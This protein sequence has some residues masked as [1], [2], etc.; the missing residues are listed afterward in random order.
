MDEMVKNSSQN[1][2][3]LSI[4]DLCEM[5]ISKWYWFLV[6][7][8]A[9]MAVT[10][11]YLM[12]QP[13]VYTRTATV[14]I[15]DDK[16]G[17]S[18]KG[19][20]S[21]TFADL[22]FLRFQTN[23]YNE[24]FTI[25]SPTLMAE[26]V[27][28]LGLNEAYSTREGLKPYSY[29]NNSPVSVRLVDRQNIGLRFDIRIGENGEYTVEKFAMGQ[30]K[31]KEPVNG[32]LGDTLSTPV[33]RIEILPT[34]YMTDDCV[35]KVVSYS[36]G[37]VDAVAANYVKILDA[38]LGDKDATILNLSIENTSVKRAEDILNTLIDVYNEKWILDKNQISESTSNFINDRLQMIER[39]LGEV[40]EVIAEYKS[41]HL[42][43]DVEEASRLYMNQ[44]ASYKKE[45]ATLNT[46]LEMAKFIRE[47]LSRK[48]AF[49]LLPVNSGIESSQVESQI[50]EYNAMVL[51]HNRLLSHSSDS[52][53][54]VK[55]MA[56]SL[57]FMRSA[58]EQ[59]VDNLI[60]SLNNQ[61]RTVTTEDDA[62]SGR[63][64]SGP[65]Q[66]KY[67]LSVERQQKVKA[68]LYLYLLQKREENELSRAFTAY[69][70]RVIT[71]PCGSPKPTSPNKARVL[72]VALFF[73]MALPAGVIFLVE[74]MNTRVR[75]RK[76]IEDMKIPF[77]G[78]IP[79]AELSGRIRRKV[80][81]YSRGKLSGSLEESDE[82]LQLVV[83]PLSRNIVNEAFRVVRT[84]LEFMLGKEEDN[85]VIM[86]TS[87]N[88]GS[89]KSFI[90]MNLATSFTIR[91]QKTIV[92]DLDLRRA[93]LSRFVSS[94][95]KGVANYLNGQI[96]DWETIVVRGEKNLVPDVIPVGTV[97]P[98]PSEL[99]LK[100]RLATLIS[101]L[102]NRY[103]CIII[104]CPPVEIVADTSIVN[105][106]A[107]MTLLVIRVGLMKREMLPVVDGY[108]AEG[109]FKN[110]A[111]LLNGTVQ[112]R[113]RYGYGYG[114]YGNKR[115]RYGNYAGYAE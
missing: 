90:S 59:S 3:T 56:A 83:K 24:L 65:N 52:N 62:T 23:I 51:E 98:N 61:I 25:K 7:F 55:N 89:G 22:G 13:A 28:R 92:I 42:L 27:S 109:K 1:E 74:T 29:Y 10:L 14:L 67:L 106:F 111:L 100:P 57:G 41:E 81:R 76:D 105:N 77:L 33:G 115:G 34:V 20:S 11:L 31:W 114:Y 93:S 96:D 85:K 17:Y 86:T 70:T 108:Y 84:N 69:N 66:A 99:L 73:A 50:A 80:R 95:E 113:G 48:E 35:G 32:R 5:F 53:P 19:T 45:L 26:V 44:A 91:E 68:E 107:D 87:M 101:E 4:R 94:P 112:S 71:P 110:M 6:S 30:D 102:R 40:D 39:E 12:T 104:D 49:L 64:A 16:P 46:Q 88:P 37:S 18:A 63:L 9:V 38:Q 15:K 36:F 21:A 43:P 60:V 58:I 2:E 8:V 78:E 103:D 47:E 72:L 82:N 79:L 97:P 75:G 54:L